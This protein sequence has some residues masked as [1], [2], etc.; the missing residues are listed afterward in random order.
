MRKATRDKDQ[1]TRSSTHVE[2]HLR[3]DAFLGVFL[4]EAIARDQPLQFI[5]LRAHDDDRR[6]AEPLEHVGLKE[7]RRVEHHE[8]LPQH[9]TIVDELLE[10]LPHNEGLVHSI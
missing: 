6:V 1:T 2:R 4:T 7:E 8:P 10:H 5:C 9:E 3:L